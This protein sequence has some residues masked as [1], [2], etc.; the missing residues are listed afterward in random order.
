MKALHIFLLFFLCAATSFAQSYEDL[1]QKSY[2]HVD[3]NELSVAEE[4]LKSAMRIEPANPLNYALLTNL[5]TIQRRQG[6]LDDAL[7]SYSSALSGHSNDITILEN[8]ASLYTELGDTEKALNDYNTL[9]FV[10]PN[11]QE[12]LYCRGLLYVQTKNF[13]WAEQDFDKLLE[14][15]EKSVRGRMGHATLEKMRGNFDESERIYNYL[16]SEMP[17]EWIL[18]EGRADLYFMMGKNARAMADIEKVFV[19]SKP[20][21]AL[22]ILRG[23]IK[24]AQYEK[25]R[26]AIDFKKAASMGYDPIVVEELMKIAKSK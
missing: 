17:R 4:C 19:E 6:K 9:L 20:T 7:I 18:Y 21:A 8:R 5:G 23:K 26:A 14:L 13:L 16:I 25:E 11:H 10:H 1:I 2:D 12:S 3:K 22:Y 15:N 24:L